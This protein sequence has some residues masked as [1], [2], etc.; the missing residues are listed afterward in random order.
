MTFNKFIELYY[1]YDYSNRSKKKSRQE[2]SFQSLM[3]F[4]ALHRQDLYRRIIGSSFDCTHRIENVPLVWIWLNKNWD[5]T[6]TEEITFT[7][8]IKHKN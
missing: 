2:T 6:I 7:T 4:I 5:D 8:N 3:S 1:F